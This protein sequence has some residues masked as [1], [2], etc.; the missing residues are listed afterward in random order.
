MPKVLN[1]AETCEVRMGEEIS[2]TLLENTVRR[3]AVEL[4]ISLQNT[5]GV[6][7]EQA[8][9]GNNGV[10]LK[11]RRDFDGYEC[12][13]AQKY[14]AKLYISNL[15]NKYRLSLKNN[16]KKLVE[17]AIMKPVREVEKKINLRLLENDIRA[18]PEKVHEPVV[19][20]QE[21]ELNNIT[22]KTILK[23]LS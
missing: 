1:S 12:F 20:L 14:D 17:S 21:N 7:Y 13:S 5:A 4:G 2:V 19:D 9:D 3:L 16:G 18:E 23:Y 11:Y 15:D 10:A 22:A 8:L 6:S